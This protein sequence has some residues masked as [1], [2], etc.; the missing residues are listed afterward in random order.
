MK[1]VV[2]SQK[3][4]TNICCS[5]EIAMSIKVNTTSPGLVFMEECFWEELSILIHTCL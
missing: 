5:E 1:K 4:L 2:T 3:F